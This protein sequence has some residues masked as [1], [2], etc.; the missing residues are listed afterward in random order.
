VR[1]WVGLLVLGGTFL[2]LAATVCVEL[3]ILLCDFDGT[4]T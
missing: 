4:R 3:S 1:G 2:R